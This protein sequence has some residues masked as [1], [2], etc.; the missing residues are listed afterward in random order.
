MN[1][2][3][4]QKSLGSADIQKLLAVL[5]HR[6][7]FLLIDRIVDIDGDDS[8]TGIKN[9]TINEPHFTGH[10]PAQPIMPGVLIL[11]AMAQTAGAISMFK[12]G[13]ENAGSVFL[14]TIDNAKFRRPVVPG[15]QMLLRVKKM[16]QRGNISK[17]ACIAEV[18]GVK[19]AEADVSAMTGA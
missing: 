3:V 18:D 14:L 4:E 5:P 1:E 11:E 10:F 7:P 12:M 8:A 13:L 17:F 9:V 6:Y 19:V 15:D 2:N 16:K